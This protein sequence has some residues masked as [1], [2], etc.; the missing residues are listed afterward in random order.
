M[1]RKGKFKILSYIVE[2]YLIF[3]TSLN[4]N[5]K[6][7]AFS[8]V[9]TKDF[10]PLISILNNFLKKGF[11]NCYSIQIDIS[12]R[13]NKFFILNF[14]DYRKERI[15]KFFNERTTHGDEATGYAK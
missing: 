1:V 12:Q 4:R 10:Y 3:Y 11:L 13:D 5:K 14:E 7:L 2:E 15:I 6:I 8:I 9:E